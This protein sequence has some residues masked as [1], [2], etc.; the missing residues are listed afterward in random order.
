MNLYQATSASVGQ[1]ISQLATSYFTYFKCHK[2]L[3]DGLESLS[4][5]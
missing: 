5:W 2:L 1:R 4:M 3:L